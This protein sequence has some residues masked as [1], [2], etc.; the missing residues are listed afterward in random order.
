M[1][2]KKLIV[3]RG[4]E[5]VLQALRRLYGAERVHVKVRLADIFEV[6]DPCWTAQER[7]LIFKAH[8]DFT[9]LGDDNRA[10]MAFEFD[11]A[12]HQHDKKQRCLDALKASI[13]DKGGLP[14]LRISTDV[15]QA[16]TR[17]AQQVGLAEDE[18]LANLIKVLIEMQ[19]VSLER[20]KA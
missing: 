15:F 5:A 9:V 19:V 14:L 13:C 10:Q 12:Y 18:A 2:L 7:D 17:R 6:S 3:S 16:V 11:G 8:F 1:P 4:E 20:V